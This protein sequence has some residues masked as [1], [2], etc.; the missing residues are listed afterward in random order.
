MADKF[1]G[2]TKRPY[3]DRDVI[4][5]KAQLT[6]LEMLHAGAEERASIATARVLQL[7]TELELARSQVDAMVGE[8]IAMVAESRRLMN[9]LEDAH[10]RLE[11][12]AETQDQ[13]KLLR[14]ANRRLTEELVERGNS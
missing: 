4:V 3:G 14:A 7:Q 13:N 2:V 5:D 8:S 10:A 12:A 11:E 6:T 1:V 9:S